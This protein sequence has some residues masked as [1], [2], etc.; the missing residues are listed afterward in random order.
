MNSITE[1]L[2]T[3]ITWLHRINHNCRLLFLTLLA[4]H[5]PQKAH[6][7]FSVFHSSLRA[8]KIVFQ[9]TKANFSV[10]F[11]RSLFIAFCLSL[12]SLF[13][14]LSR[15][16]ISVNSL[17]PLFPSFICRLTIRWAPTASPMLQFGRKLK[18]NSF[19]RPRAFNFDSFSRST[20]KSRK[21]F[22]LSPTGPS[23]SECLTIHSG[24]EM[25]F[26]RI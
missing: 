21:N 20:M 15:W 25:N 23:V 10:F 16:T 11:S 19:Y 12:R 7:I 24:S 17:N 14:R 26:S 9:L 18:F 13:L 22:N 5:A 4:S 1:M 3:D 6:F 2:R 8:Q